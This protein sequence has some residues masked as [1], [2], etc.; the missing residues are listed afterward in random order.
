LLCLI[1]L[2]PLTVLLWIGSDLVELRRQHPR[3]DMDS[4]IQRLSEWALS[5]GWRAPLTVLLLLALVVLQVFRGRLQR[6]PGYVIRLWAAA[7]AVYWML[8]SVTVVLAALWTLG[9]GWSTDTQVNTGVMTT[10]GITFY[11]LAVECLVAPVT[12]IG[13]LVRLVSSLTGPVARPA[14]PDP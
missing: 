2:V 9:L 10:A 3:A 14:V 11:V 8:V 4:G 13:G 1:A 6:H 12:L 5:D 7:G